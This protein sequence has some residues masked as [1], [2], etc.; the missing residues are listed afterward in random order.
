MANRGRPK[1]SKNKK[2]ALDRKAISKE[3]DAKHVLQNKLPIVE[4]SKGY[5]FQLTEADLDGIIQAVSVGA[6]AKY[7]A[8][9][10][11][12]SEGELN[13]AINNSRRVKEAV[14]RGLAIDEMEMTSKFREL[15]MQGS[16]PAAIFYQ[17]NK[18]GWLDS[19]VQNNKGDITINVVTGI[20]RDNEQTL[21]DAE[22]DHINNS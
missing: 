5:R 19:P 4:N 17:K 9:Q 3:L 7:V 8:Y 16:V 10:L 2:T 12:I 20:D 14:Q 13:V 11:G 21:I 18:H 15:A 1:G 22:F 6:S